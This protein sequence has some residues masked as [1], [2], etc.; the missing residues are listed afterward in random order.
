M[1]TMSGTSDTVAHVRSCRA[2]NGHQTQA[3]CVSYMNFQQ[4]GTSKP[5]T[6][7]TVQSL[8]PLQRLE[9]YPAIVVFKTAK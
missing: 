1:P 7:Q 2:L 9:I 5:R 3:L 8:S 6:H 4:K